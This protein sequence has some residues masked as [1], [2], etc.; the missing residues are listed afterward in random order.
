[1]STTAT[2]LV[3]I[4]CEELPPKALEGLADAFA[5]SFAREL[6]DAELAFD[7]IVPY[8]TPRRLALK[9]MGLAAE[10]PDRSEKPSWSGG[11]SR[12]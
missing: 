8:A 3:E 5:A 2:L 10:Q 9:A 7:E 12:L 11:E 6:N 4:G 1:M